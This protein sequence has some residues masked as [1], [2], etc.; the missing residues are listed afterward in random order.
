[1]AAKSIC[2]VGSE[3]FYSAIEVISPF[4]CWD[5]SLSAVKVTMRLTKFRVG[6][7]FDTVTRVG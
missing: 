2:G 5:F 3:R 7:Y 6:A 4:L 1:M